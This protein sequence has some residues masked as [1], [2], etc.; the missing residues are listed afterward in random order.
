MASVDPYWN[1]CTPSHS[2]HQGA[3]Q[4]GSI[5]AWYA[6]SAAWRMPF[7]RDAKRRYGSALT[8]QLEA[9]A[10]NYRHEGIEIRGRASPVPV[11]IR[12][13]AQPK[14]NTYGL[15]PADYPRVYADAG[16]DSPH[17]MPDGSL[18]LF[19]PG[20]PIERRWRADLGLLTLLDLT[21]DHLYFETYWRH[22]GGTAG[23]Q[24]LGPE[25]AHGFRGRSA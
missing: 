22:T 17:R 12:F 5:P 21:A 8:A 14:Y 11:I 9:D 1:G 6:T 25:A 18:C 23:G 4:H 24:W 16:A 15:E 2:P 3:V 20:D 10:L 19:Y 7:Q 13:V